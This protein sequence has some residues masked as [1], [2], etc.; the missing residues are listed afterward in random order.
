M[1]IHRQIEE[2]TNER[3]KRCKIW[4]LIALSVMLFIVVLSVMGSPHDTPSAHFADYK[5]EAKNSSSDNPAPKP[6]KIPTGEGLPEYLRPTFKLIA[7]LV[8][9]IKRDAYNNTYKIVGIYLR[10]EQLYTFVNQSRLVLLQ[11]HFVRNVRTQRQIA[12]CPLRVQRQLAQSCSI[13]AH[14]QTVFRRRL[15]LPLG[16]RKVEVLRTHLARPRNVP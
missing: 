14:Q 7:S 5:F 11:W 12:V 4:T 6:P 8:G 3:V 13:D 16:K 2:R 15:G 1:N 9:T 10:D